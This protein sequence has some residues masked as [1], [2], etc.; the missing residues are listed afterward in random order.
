MAIQ[1]L[2]ES[3]AETLFDATLGEW[4]KWTKMTY[5][6]CYS[7]EQTKTAMT[8]TMAW[9]RASKTAQDVWSA[10]DGAEQIVYVVGMRGGY[11]CFNSTEGQDK[12]M[13]VVF[14][15]LDGRLTVNVRGAHNLH[16]DPNDC[17]GS[18][19]PMNNRIALLHEFGHAKQWTERPLMFDGHFIGGGDSAKKFAFAS[20]IRDKAATLIK[21]C[22]LCGEHVETDPRNPKLLLDPKRDKVKHPRALHIC[23]GKKGAP[24][25][26]PKPQ[27]VSRHDEK[28]NPEG[29]KPPVWGVQIEMD[30][31]ARHEW[32]ICAELGLPI[33]KNYRDINGESVGEAS[34]SSQIRQR[35]LAWERA[36]Q[37]L[38]ETKS[39]AL[40]PGQCPYCP[41]KFNS[42]SFLRSHVMREHPGKPQID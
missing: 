23:A 36:Q 15:D 11:Q 12:N 19:L 6:G 7:A 24:D 31:M 34:L 1:W 13:P 30:N 32:P 4:A 16:L 33:R 21:R 2:S 41:R 18:V 40:S 3:E 28:T 17:Q 25:V 29:F 42:N 9:A 26:V 5:K 37:T 10:V 14:I 39:V 8:E 20:A 38:G 27:E 22:P 35:A